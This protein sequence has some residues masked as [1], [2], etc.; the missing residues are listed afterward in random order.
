MK[1]LPYIISGVAVLALIIV[2]AVVYGG[3]GGG[4]NGGRGSGDVV[5]GDVQKVVLSFKNGNYYP[6]TV[7][8]EAGKPVQLSLDSSVGGCYRSFTIRQLGVAK[9]LA[10]PSN[11]VTFTP[12]KG[13]YRFACSMGMG[14]GTL[15]AE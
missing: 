7:T 12:S 6:N 1:N 15:V 5:S 11:S 13:T 14:T 10:S 3:F 8:V 9:Y 2:L 4:D